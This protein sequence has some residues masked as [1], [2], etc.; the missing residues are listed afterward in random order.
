[1]TLI[2]WS[3]IVWPYTSFTDLKLSISI[4]IRACRPFS[5]SVRVF[6]ISFSTV[7][8]LN[9]LVISSICDFVFQAFCSSLLFCNLRFTP[10]VL[11]MRVSAIR[12]STGLITN[13]SAPSANASDWEDTDSVFVRTIT[14]VSLKPSIF[15]LR[16]STSKPSIP[17]MTRSSSTRSMASLSFSMIVRHSS[18]ETASAKLKCSPRDCLITTL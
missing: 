13:S 15:C 16:R 14:G 9:R 7:I 10:S 17:G 6:V 2:T 5:C 3:P 4:T 1:M 18:P 12:V 8:L 11:L